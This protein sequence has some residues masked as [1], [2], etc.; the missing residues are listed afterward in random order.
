M[1]SSFWGGDTPVV[2]VKKLED[3]WDEWCDLS[4]DGVVKDGEIFSVDGL[5]DLLDEG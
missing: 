1:S 4:C 5:D 2:V 3:G